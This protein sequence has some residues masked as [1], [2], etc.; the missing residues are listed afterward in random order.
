MLSHWHVLID[1]GEK[2]QKEDDIWPDFEIE[3]QGAPILM[4]LK[5]HGPQEWT[6]CKDSNQEIPKIVLHQP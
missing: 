4:L 1:Y 2:S 5:H 3:T 6:D